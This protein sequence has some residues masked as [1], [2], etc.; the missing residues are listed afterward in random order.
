VLGYLSIS[1]TNSK[2]FSCCYM[3]VFIFMNSCLNL[4]SLCLLQFKFG[5]LSLLLWISW[6]QTTY[7]LVS[8][9]FTLLVSVFFTCHGL[10]F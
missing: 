9:I 8:S 10:M 1:E 4:K 6:Q 5:C 2:S 3:F 7:S